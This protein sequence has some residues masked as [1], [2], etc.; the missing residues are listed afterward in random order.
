MPMT[1]M[2]TRNHSAEMETAGKLQQ[3]MFAKWGGGAKV[4]QWVVQLLLRYQGRL[5]IFC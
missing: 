3:F 2:L 4:I 1:T 5:G